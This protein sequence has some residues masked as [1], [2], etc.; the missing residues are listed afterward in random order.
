MSAAMLGRGEVLI[1]HFPNALDL[2]KAIGVNLE[3]VGGRIFFQILE[4]MV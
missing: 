2:T 4:Q 1:L 3:W